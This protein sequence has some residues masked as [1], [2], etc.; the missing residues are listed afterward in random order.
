MAFDDTDR[1]DDGR[2]AQRMFVVFL[3]S[4]SKNQAREEKGQF[5][6]LVTSIVNYENNFNHLNAMVNFVIH[7]NSVHLA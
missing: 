6:I 4:H 7:I 3:S 5:Y 2:V 1:L